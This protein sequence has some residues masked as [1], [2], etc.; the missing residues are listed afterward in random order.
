MPL[1]RD[2]DVLGECDVRVR[3]LTVSVTTENAPR[4][5]RRL[6][7]G[8]SLSVPRGS[9]YMVVGLNGSGKSTLLRCLAGLPPTVTRTGEVGSESSIRGT[10]DV[11]RPSSLVFQNPDDQVVMPTV[12]SDVAFAMDMAATSC[13]Y[14]EQATRGVDVAGERTSRALR[15]LAD[16]G[17]AEF[18]DRQMSTL[19]GGQRQRVA[20]AG[21]VAQRPRVLLCD[22]LTTFLDKEDQMA[23][24]SV[25]RRLVKGMSCISI[26]IHPFARGSGPFAAKSFPDSVVHV[27]GRFRDGRE[28]NDDVRMDYPQARG[29]GIC[30]CRRTARRWEAAHC[31]RCGQGS[32]GAQGAM[33]LRC[34]GCA[35]K[36]IQ[37]RK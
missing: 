27:R 17:M 14:T 32:A 37:K 11:A 15:A 5:T 23:V 10:I 7:S 18:A 1:P 28:R 2:E 6:L 33:R 30:G 20:I 26:T 24:L 4:E 36:K 16:V 13:D 12:L 21:A 35:R 22:E 25:V 31:G 3:G 29:A 8:V 9:M 19:S 34:S